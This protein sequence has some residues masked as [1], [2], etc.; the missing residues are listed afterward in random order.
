[1]TIPTK[2]QIEHIRKNIP[3]FVCEF[4]VECIPTSE[5]IEKIITEW[6]KI[7]RKQK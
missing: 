5:V 1:M 2:E 4:D 7:R 6:E 3:T